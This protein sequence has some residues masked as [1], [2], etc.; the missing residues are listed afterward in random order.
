MSEGRRRTTGIFGGSFNPVHN[1]HI[2]LCEALVE[3]GIV[4]SV[5]LTLSP[6]NPLKAH[7][8]ELIA[9]S[10]RLEMLRIATEGR[11]GLEVCDIELTMPRPSY[12]I[13]TLQTLARLYPESDFRLIIGSDNMLVFDRWKDHE[14][15]MERFR[16]IVYPRPGYPCAE[17]TEG[18][19]EFA[20]SSTEI[21]RMISEGCDVNS[22]LP[23]GVTEYIKAN[24][25]YS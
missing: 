11:K 13:N 6:L 12:T 15:I 3:R 9:D 5:W 14:L 1:G 21:R 16:P 20:V 22:L 2:A 8:E 10:S 23:P 18:L 24:N 25:L 19:P 4:D 17:E 7:P